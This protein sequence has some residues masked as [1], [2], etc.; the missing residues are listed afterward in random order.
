M[1]NK[2][3]KIFHLFLYI[4][5]FVATPVFAQTAK[6][7]IPYT[8]YAAFYIVGFLLFALAVLFAGIMIFDIREREPVSEK[9]VKAGKKLVIDEAALLLDH[10]YD[11]IRELDNKLPLWFQLLFLITVIFGI[12]YMINYHLLGKPNLMIDEYNNEVTTAQLQREELLKSGALINESNVTLLSAPEDLQKGKE[13]YTANC[14]PCHGTGGEGIVGPNLTDDYWIHG[15]GIKNVFRTISQG[16]PDKGMITWST[17]LSPKQIQQVASFVLSL[18][19]TNP[20]NAKPPEGT[21][22]IDS[23]ANNTKT[24]T[25][26]DAKNKNKTDTL[27]THNKIKPDTSVTNTKIKPDTTEINKKGYRRRYRR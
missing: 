15:G 1:K 9:A 13:V 3:R 25:E 26:T 8:E 24:K 19:G 11:G 22:W 12:V 10:N 23:S 4:L 16:V 2:K 27:A 21:I 17:T 6:K 20:P 5:T 14:I 18:H 7:E